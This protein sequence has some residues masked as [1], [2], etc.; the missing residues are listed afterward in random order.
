MTGKYIIY[1]FRPWRNIAI[2]VLLCIF[3]MLAGWFGG[4]QEKSILRFRYTQMEDR[5]SMISESYKWLAQ[6]K[7][8]LL[9][10]NQILNTSLVQLE[11]A[12][13]IDKESIQQLKTDLS[14]LEDQ[15]FQFREEINFYRSVIDSSQSATGLEI[16]GI[17]IRP[18]NNP[19]QYQYKTVLT[20][21]S[22]KN[23]TAD[24][25]MDIFIEGSGDDKKKLSLS[26]ADILVDEGAEFS[27]SFKHFKVFSGQIRLP[28]SFTPE[29]SI[30]HLKTKKD[31]KLLLEKMFDWPKK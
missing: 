31:G 17:H 16:Q 20:N 21:L 19:G 23:D 28:D 7:N 5:L 24:G 14:A 22:K 18:L 8:N 12:G 30:I 10:E 3:S 25:W 9:E 6:E 11:Q 13:D 15:M 1:T 2:V 26:L 27:F 29:R 4:K